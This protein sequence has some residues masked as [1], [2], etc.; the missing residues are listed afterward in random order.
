[1]SQKIK[2]NK[3]NRSSRQS[4]F[5][6]NSEQ[7]RPNKRLSPFRGPSNPTEN[8]KPAIKRKQRDHRS[9]EPTPPIIDLT[10]DTNDPIGFKEG[11]FFS[12]ELKEN[13]ES[14]SDDEEEYDLYK[15]IELVKFNFMSEED[16][17]QFGV[18]EV[19]DTRLSGPLPNSL[20][21]LRM[22]PIDNKEMCETCENN[23]KECPGH[24]G[25][26]KLN[27]KI[28]HPL[29]SKTI[30]EYLTLFC[31]KCHRLMMTKEKLYL[32]GF[33]KYREE[34][35]YKAIYNFVY[36]SV[37][38]CPHCETV[39][40][41]YSC[42]DDKYMME[43]RDSKIPL[44]YDDIYEIFS[45][46]R[47]ED[48]TLLGFEDENVHPIRMMIGNLLVVPPCVRP[49]VKS[50][51]GENMHDD[52][53]YKYIDIIKTNKK[54]ELE[55]K[56][57]TKLDEIDRL[58]YHIRTLMDNNKGKAR[59]IQGKR[60]LKCIKK[61]LSGKQ[62]RIRQNIQGKR[63]DFCARTVIGP[64][65]YS[66]VEELVVPQEV[67]RTLTYPIT[68]N[69]LN[70]EKC[71]KL[72]DDGK[73]NF[74]IRKDVIKSAKV[75]L[76]TQGFRLEQGD[77]VYRK[78]VPIEIANVDHDGNVYSGMNKKIQLE[79][80]DQVYRNNKLI[81]NAFYHQPKRKRFELMIGDIIE[82]QLQ[83]GDLVVFNRQPTLWKG[84]MRAKKV[85][86]LPGKTFRFSLASTAAFNADFDGDEI[87]GLQIKGSLTPTD[88]KRP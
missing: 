86:I 27:A 6:S 72:L 9:Q 34:T 45:N 63:S 11:V 87:N 82:R 62:G 47:P 67:A 49:F 8:E 78:N 44:R 68:V 71:K 18:V 58:M 60:P 25:Y 41:S 38:V 80:T 33:N 19:T 85:K 53:T 7:K 40:P 26:I 81:P 75:V 43:M 76:W 13:E 35:K 84:S 4:E 79:S 15:D 57:K 30:L 10:K 2:F 56:E 36:N 23:C 16:V 5:E 22:G 24:F 42:I 14:E 51:D 32:L 50:D 61:R 29:R 74:I 28:P 64:E 17:T 39:T 83:D 1:M 52:L 88:T 3:L 31:N 69:K 54:I 48:V 37:K 77:V 12:N 70:K 59:D 65:V 21:D 20:Y 66:R 55:T 46:I 73:V